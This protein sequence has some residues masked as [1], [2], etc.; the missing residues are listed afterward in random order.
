[1]SGRDLGSFVGGTPYC[2]VWG[3]GTENVSGAAFRQRRVDGQATMA[4]DE[5]DCLPWCKA[6]PRYIKL[7]HRQCALRS[8]DG[9]VRV[10]YIYIRHRG[11]ESRG[12]PLIHCCSRT[13]VIV[14]Y[15]S[16]F[17]VTCTRPGAY[18]LIA[19]PSRPPLW[20]PITPP[21]PTWIDYTAPTHARYKESSAPPFW[22]RDFLSSVPGE[23][24][25]LLRAK[26]DPTRAHAL[27]P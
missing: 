12:T 21:L 4:R 10:V 14:L 26:H 16:R 7:A 20:W 3:G 6:S 5:R 9:G 1:M 25:S 13:T 2:H 17:E 15:S 8:G 11:G 19:A 24:A 23:H 22:R 18:R 27:V